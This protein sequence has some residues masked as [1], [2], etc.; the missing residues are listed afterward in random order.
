MLED[1]ALHIVEDLEQPG[2]QF[3]LDFHP[4]PPASN[5]TSSASCQAIRAAPSR[6]CRSAVSSGVSI[7]AWTT[8][9]SFSFLSSTPALP[10]GSVS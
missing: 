10:A 4:R 7:P 9:P 3:S 2:C 6:M 1:R 5:V 8:L